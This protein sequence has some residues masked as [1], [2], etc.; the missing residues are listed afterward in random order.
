MA[1]GPLHFFVSIPAIQPILLFN[2]SFRAESTRTRLECRIPQGHSL[3]D[4]EL[5]T[6]SADYL[7]SVVVEGK[8]DQL[9]GAARKKVG[10]IKKVFNQ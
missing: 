9:K 2:K 8:K 3:R 6:G 5:C 4:A 10:E 7:I 1:A